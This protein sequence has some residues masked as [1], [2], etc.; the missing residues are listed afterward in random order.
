MSPAGPR[1]FGLVDRSLVEYRDQLGH[2][3]LQRLR[4]P[5]R[6]P[7]TRHLLLQPR[8]RRRDALPE[9]RIDDARELAH[10]QHRRIVEPHGAG[11]ETGN[12][13]R[14]ALLAHR[15]VARVAVE[16]D[17]LGEEAVAAALRIDEHVRGLM[18]SAA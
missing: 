13:R 2:L 15:M 8:H 1:A 6:I 7:A 17:E 3:R 11:A 5:H 14:P 18:T 16:Q 9:P 4:L 10:H 12:P